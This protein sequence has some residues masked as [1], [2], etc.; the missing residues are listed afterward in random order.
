MKSDSTVINPFVVGH[1]HVYG[2]CVYDSRYGYK[3]AYEACADL[4]PP[5]VQDENGTLCE[6][7]VMLRNYIAAMNLK[8]RLFKALLNNA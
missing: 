7:P 5:I 1:S 3:P 8:N 6:S 4:L 2:W